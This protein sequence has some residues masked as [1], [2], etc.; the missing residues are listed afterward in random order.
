MDN[1]L[2][3]VSAKNRT[4]NVINE[5]NKTLNRFKQLR[6][7][8]SNFKEDG[9]VNAP[10]LNYKGKQHKS[11]INKLI[12]LENDFKWLIPI[13]KN[14]KKLYDIK[15]FGEEKMNDYIVDTTDNF[16]ETFNNTL[17]SYR[18]DDMNSSN[19]K[20]KFTRERLNNIQRNFVEPKMKENIIAKIKNI[21]LKI[22]SLNLQ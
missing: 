5:I 15:L 11:L 3:T 17:N 16:I 18:N 13:V 7:E 8:F 6:L 21:R 19:D 4:K 9:M 14:K 20:Y 22:K 2:S 10:K 1:L 12:N